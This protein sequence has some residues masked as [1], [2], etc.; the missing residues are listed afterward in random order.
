MEKKPS[1]KQDKK[2]EELAEA[3]AI[4]FASVSDYIYKQAFIHGFKHA[5]TKKS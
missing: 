1:K 2:I 4:W 5:Q 3:H